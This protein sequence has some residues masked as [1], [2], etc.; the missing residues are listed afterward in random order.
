MTHHANPE[1]FSE[2]AEV[3]EL[4]V[5]EGMENDIGWAELAEHGIGAYEALR[6]AE[7]S[8]ESLSD[9]EIEYELESI[10]EGMS[11]ADIE[12]FW[13][14]VKNAARGVAGLASKVARPA[15][16]TVGTVA[17]GIFGGPAGARIGGQIGGAVGG[18]ASRGLSHISRGGRVRMNAR[19]YGKRVRRRARRVGRAVGPIVSRAA[20]QGVN[21]FNQYIRQPGVQQAVGR[22]AM[23]LGGQIMNAAGQALSANEVAE[24]MY[25]LAQMEG[26]ETES[27]ESFGLG[28]GMDGVDMDSF[29]AWADQL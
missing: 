22:A 25:Q 24:A 20:T 18:L 26:H 3:G 1:T 23:G 14:S 27:F 6:L 7:P 29:I 28:E 17:G 10:F 13:Q 5:P 9:S 12:G 15:L 21:R 19:G 4:F 16:R 2:Y 11:E 8:F